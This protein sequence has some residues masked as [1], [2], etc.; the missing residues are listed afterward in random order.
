MTALQIYGLV[1]PLLLAGFGWAIVVFT[2]ADH[3]PR[4]DPNRR[5]TV[6]RPAE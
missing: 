5:S 3:R 2:R 1:A 6:E 4:V